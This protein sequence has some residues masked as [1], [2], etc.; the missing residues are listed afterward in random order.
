MGRRSFIAKAM[1]AVGNFS[2]LSYALAQVISLS[3]AINKSGRQR[4]LSQRLAKAYLQLG[5]GVEVEQS[6]KILESSLSSFEHQLAEL[7]SFAPTPDNKQILSE[8]DKNWLQYK[9]VLL[10]KQPNQQDARAIM[11]LNE[12]VLSIAQ[13]ATV[14]LETYSGTVVGQVVNISGRQRMLS[15]R[16]AKFY[17]ARQWGVAPA[18]V[19]ARLEAARKDFID[20][21]T[22]LQ[23]SHSNTPRIR[24][25]LALAQ[26]QWMFFNDAL[27][28]IEDTKNARQYSIHVATTSERILSAMDGITGMYQQIA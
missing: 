10:E 28:K 13:K 26:Q 1:L 16:M 24:E 15:Q 20:G 5:L 7:K 23:A 22:I 9:K 4:M 19:M 8:M 2:L 11:V 12:D 27:S 14:Q 6:R 21:M 25:E 3:E 17:Q 18:D